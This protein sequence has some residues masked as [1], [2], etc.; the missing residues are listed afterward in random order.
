MPGICLVEPYAGGSHALL[1]N[2]VTQH[3]PSQVDTFL[4]GPKKWGWRLRASALSFSQSIPPGHGHNYSL[5]LCTSMLNLAEFLALR[6]DFL[7]TRKLLYFH[8][9]QLTYP[10]QAQGAHEERDYYFGHANMVSAMVADVVLWNSRFNFTSFLQAI[11]HLIAS[12]PFQSQDKPDIKRICENIRAKSFV[13]Y[14]PLQVPLV[15]PPLKAPQ[16]P[17]CI[18]FPHRWEFDKNPDEFVQVIKQL[19]ESECVFTIK[20]FG[21]ENF[22]GLDIPG[23]FRQSIPHLREGTL[24][25]CGRIAS[26][27]DYLQALASCDVVVST[28]V[29]EFFGISMVE[30]S[31]LGVKVLCPKRLSYPELFAESAL[32][33]SQAR[34]VKQLK[35]YSKNPVVLRRNRPFSE[36]LVWSKIDAETSAIH[37]HLVQI[38]PSRSRHRIVL[39]CLSMMLI[40][41]RHTFF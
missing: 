40:L 4:M 3:Y 17:M 41:V 22:Q 7:G 38:Q 2:F 18:G 30:A 39:V 10:T 26:R 32:Y 1:V 24:V 8:E 16:E 20:V 31:R 11:P 15:P 33:T 9:N 13:V 37:E 19:H 6:P 25:H 12:I 35:Y 36:L 28:S 27:H 14:F 5:L 21:G 34:L 23:H 29:H